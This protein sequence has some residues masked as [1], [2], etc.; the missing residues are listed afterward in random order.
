MRWANQPPT[1]VCHSRNPQAGIHSPSFPGCPL[2]DCGHD[3]IG[4]LLQSAQTRRL[5]PRQ[6][7]APRP[8]ARPPRPSRSARWISSCRAGW[9]EPP[10]GGLGAPRCREFTRQAASCVAPLSVLKLRQ[11]FTSIGIPETLVRSGFDATDWG[12]ST[13]SLWRRS[14]N[15]KPETGNRKPVNSAGFTFPVF[16]FRFSIPSLFGFRLCRVRLS[17]G[18]SGSHM[19]VQLSRYKPPSAIRLAPL[20]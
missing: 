10:Q 8:P 16:G 13:H 6:R 9:G 18:T 2:K 11:G 1:E 12:F 17:Y 4:P 7:G 14:K 15:G 19:R 20:M 5:K 3:G